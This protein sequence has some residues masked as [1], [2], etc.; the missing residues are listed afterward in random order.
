MLG[1]FESF[2]LKDHATV[3]EQ[4]FAAVV[5]WTYEGLELTT[6]EALDGER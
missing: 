5:T 4:L 6:A 3:Q 1:S 2:G